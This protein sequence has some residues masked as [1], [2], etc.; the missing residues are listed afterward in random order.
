MKPT[1]QVKEQDFQ[2]ALMTALSE[3]RVLVVWR[4]NSGKLVTKNRGALT[5]APKGS[6]DITG[7]V[8]GC[9]LGV[10]IE[11]KVPPNKRTKEQLHFAELCKT[12]GIVYAYVELDKTLDLKDNV[13]NA[14]ESVLLAVEERT[15]SLRVNNVD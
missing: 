15:R 2:N 9:G 7:L 10:E 1:E 13:S 3:T 11:V 14:V 5:L 8:I 12:W 6:G 4:Q